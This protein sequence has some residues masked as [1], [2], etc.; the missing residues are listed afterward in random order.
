M[1]RLLLVELA[2]FVEAASIVLQGKVSQAKRI[3]FT[4]ILHNELLGE[5]PY[6]HG[7]KKE[8]MSM[9]EQGSL[10]HLT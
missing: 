10:R 5:A 4:T 2:F 1:P 8:S 6:T 3:T 9:T 7:L